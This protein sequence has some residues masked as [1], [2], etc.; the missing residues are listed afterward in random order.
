M[1]NK[2]I[3]SLGT[4]VAVFAPVITAVSCNDAPSLSADQVAANAEVAKIKTSALGNI[5]ITGNVPT[6][7][8]LTTA[9]KAANTTE[10]TIASTTTFKIVEATSSS[11]TVVAVVNNTDSTVPKLVTY[12]STPTTDQGKADRAIE[13]LGVTALG[14]IYFTTETPSEAEVSAV[15]KAK[16]TAI[17]A[18]I[19]FEFDGVASATSVKVKAKSGTVSSTTSKSV[20]YSKATSQP[21]EQERATAAINGVTKTTHEFAAG[22]TVNQTAILTA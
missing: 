5:S 18:A 11:A 7:A 14:P 8:E 2:L 19:T 20:S 13:K 12:T 4:S 10:P 16:N 15:I 3:L 6:A 1:K 21:T 17:D 9:I 22:T